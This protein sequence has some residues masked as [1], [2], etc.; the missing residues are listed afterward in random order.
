ML[1]F[2]AFSI[3]ILSVAACERAENPAATASVPDALGMATQAEV[4]HEFSVGTFLEN[5]TRRDDDIFVT[6]YFDQSLLRLERSGETTTFTQLPAHP[7]GILATETGFVVTAHGTPFTEFPDFM[8]SNRVFLL[9]VRGEI[10]TETLAPGAQFLN[11]LTQLSSGEVLAADS[12]AGVVWLIDPVTAQASVFISDPQFTLDS[13]AETFRP[14]A[15]GLKVRDGALYV[16]NSSR[17]TMLRRSPAA[18]GAVEVYA[19]P[20]PVDDFVFDKDGSIVATTHGDRLIR[21]AENGDVS[22]IM[23]DGCDACTAVI[24]DPAGRGWIVLTTGGLLEGKSESARILL[25]R[26]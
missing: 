10:V 20:G 12:I 8:T 16:S 18:S 25:V 23:E 22:T 5:L 24:A 7:V 26:E 15:N 13:D 3:L 19:R 4:L 9:D 17:G 21:I 2:I 11:G 1:K 6:N 14:G